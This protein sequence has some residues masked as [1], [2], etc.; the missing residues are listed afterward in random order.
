MEIGKLKADVQKAA[1]ELPSAELLVLAAELESLR[2]W[3]LARIVA[4]EAARG[5]ETVKVGGLVNASEIATRLGVPVSWVLDQ[6]RRGKLPCVRL[7]RYVRFSIDEVLES[8]GSH[9][10]MAVRKGRRGRQ[11]ELSQWD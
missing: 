7:G 11:P 3:I 9:V 5:R 1:V 2:A 8:L 6:A 4:V 10:A